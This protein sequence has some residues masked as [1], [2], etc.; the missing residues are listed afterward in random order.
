MSEKNA[1]TLLEV[2]LAMAILLIGVVGVATLLPLSI[3]ANMRSKNI[4]IVTMLAESK[5]EE[6]KKEAAVSAAY[7]ATLDS[8][9]PETSFSPP[10]D[11]FKWKTTIDGTT[12]G[13][14]HVTLSIIWTARTKVLNE[15][16]DFLIAKR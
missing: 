5:I 6:M 2:A 14:Q 11:K 8:V 15:D 4:A 3:E 7:W 16:F 9:S 10:Y 1:F 12:T 13:L